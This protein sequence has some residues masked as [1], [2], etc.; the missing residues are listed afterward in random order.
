MDVAVLGMGIMGSRMARRLLEAGHDVRVW[1]RTR[2]KATPL[3]EAGAF[4]A[5]TP[6]EAAAGADVVLT[7]LADGPATEEVMLAEG[8][9][10]QA[11]SGIW[12]QMATVGCDET[13]RLLAG[14]GDVPFVDAPVLGTKE[15]AEKGQLL[16]L[17]SGDDAV[18]DRCVPIFEAVGKRTLRLGA[19]GAG[20][21]TKLV[22]NTWLLGMLCTLAESLAL[23]EAI[24]LPPRTFLDAI[25]GGPLG[26]PYARLKGELMIGHEFP[27]SFPARLALKDARNILRAARG[28]FDP[29]LVQVAEDRFS[30]LVER[31]LGEEDMAAVYR[32]VR[33]T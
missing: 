26:A 9:A 22:I 15:P 25:E 14:A 3:G 6:Q 18:V 12:L 33:G 23:A 30:D 32:V 27:P 16:V 29:R 11:T 8:E 7:I 21:R 4:V 24:G 17:A 28:H 1:N 5:E 13:E 31:G 2:A 20:T 19:A 10:L